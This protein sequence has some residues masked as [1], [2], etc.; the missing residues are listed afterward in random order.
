METNFNLGSLKIV[1]APLM[2]YFKQVI[3]NIESNIKVIRDE[4]KVVTNHSGIDVLNKIQK[5]LEMIGLKG[6]SKVLSVTEDALKAVREVRFDSKK[7]V[8]ILEISAHILKNSSLYTQRLVDSGIDQPTKFY[9]DYSKLSLLLGQESNIKDLFFP[10]LDLIESIS[11]QM[12][13]DLR[14][15]IFINDNSK[16]NLVLHLE[17]VQSSIQPELLKAFSVFDAFGEFYSQDEKTQYQNVCKGLYESFDYAQKLKINK[18]FYILFGIYK[19]Y[20]CVLSPVFNEKFTVYVNEKQSVIKSNLAKIERVVARLIQSVKEMEP[21]EKTGTIRLDDEDVKEVLFDLVFALENNKELKNM[22]VYK[23]LSAFFDVDYYIEQLNE[24]IIH[25]DELLP[26]DEKIEEIEKHFLDM[27]EEFNILTMKSPSADDFNIHINKLGLQN[28]KLSELLSNNKEMVPLLAQIGVAM[29]GVKNKNIEFSDLLQREISLGLVLTDYGISSFVKHNVAERLKK[30]YILQTDLQTNRIKAVCEGDLAKLESLDLPKLDST[31]Q[32]S[33]KKKTYAKIFEQLQL[34]LT[35]IEETLDYFLKN[36]GENID[37]IA[38]IYKPLVGMKGI[39]SIIGKPD[40][41]KVITKISEPWKKVIDSGN[42]EAN[43]DDLKESIALVSGLSLLVKAFVSENEVEAEEIYNNL[44]KVFYKNNQNEINNDSFVPE[45]EQDVANVDMSVELD[46][47][48]EEEIKTIDFSFELPVDDKKEEEVQEEEIKAPV[49]VE[50][51]VEIKVE[52]KSVSS[53]VKVYTESTNDPDIAEVF[54]MEAE[55]V[56]VNLKDSFEVLSSDNENKEELTNVRRYFHTLKG[57]GRMVGLEFMGEAAWM[58][59]QTLNKCLVG[60]LEFSVR[61]FQAIK[62][63]K[64][65]FEVW[66]EQL[67]TTNE[68]TVDLVSIKKEFLEINPHLTNH[69]EIDITSAPAIEES[70]E[71]S[72]EQ[73]E[74]K[75]EEP[76]VEDKPLEVNTEFNFSDMNDEPVVE[77]QNVEITTELTLGELDNQ[78]IEDKPLEITTEFNFGEFNKEPVVEENSL[79]VTTEFNFGDM[80]NEPVVEPVIENVE[81]TFDEPVINMETPDVVEVEEENV[82]IDGQL[83]SKS[84]YALFNEESGIHIEKLKQYAHIEYNEPVVLNEEF[85]RHAHTLASISASVNLVKIAKIASKLENIAVVTLERGLALSQLQ[86]N[87]VR[88]VVDNIDLF[89]EFESSEHNSYFESLI[90][91]LD[92][93]YS[94]LYRDDAFEESFDIQVDNITEVHSEEVKEEKRVVMP[95]I[96]IEEITRN[97]LIR[98][99]EENENFIQ[100]LIEKDKSNQE[101][102]SKMQNQMKEME[103]AFAAAQEDREE[104]ERLLNKALEVTKNDVRILANIVKKNMSNPTSNEVREVK[105]EPKGFFQKLF[106]K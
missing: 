38:T 61:L 51:K 48:Q 82:L 37:E 29:E 68:V 47:Q 52:P 41:S 54:L 73:I 31:S 74:F 28:N 15:G 30:D 17:K 102:I 27:K 80:N 53:E 101:L 11:E 81:F 93:L 19:L 44:M 26:T 85:M 90:E 95:E 55:E 36:E 39:F 76:A 45:F 69:V 6:L 72:Q 62:D 78:P 21:G 1:Q 2:D 18:N 34:D 97:I 9:K 43:L 79:E 67:K 8:E 92:N 13:N 84:L 88:H 40:L 7:N 104:K 20:I 12:Q 5:T 50:T 77:E 65:K 99:Q 14:A 66:V 32:K 3:E 70:L 23:E 89:K 98:V 35:K 64:E 106:G 60:E 94:E 10:K 42:T 58:V 24:N 71:E 33:D 49:V 25:N 63:M 91:N 56:L 100:S 103:K 59:E 22:P 96:N 16:K 86:M 83:V 46:E 57:S 87:A 105:P 75:F 4:K